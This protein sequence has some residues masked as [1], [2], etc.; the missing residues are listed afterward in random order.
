[1]QVLFAQ[2]FNAFAE[3]FGQAQLGHEVPR[4]RRRSSTSSSRRK[5]RRRR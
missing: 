4:R 1:M 5:R 2:Y 3:A